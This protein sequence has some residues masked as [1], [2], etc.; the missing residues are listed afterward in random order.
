VSQLAV[1][2]CAESVG[3]AA[4]TATKERSKNLILRRL[5]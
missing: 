4:A 1:G 2:H 5:K 3:V